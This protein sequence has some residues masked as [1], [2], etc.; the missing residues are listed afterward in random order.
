MEFSGTVFLVERF[1]E[2]VRFYRDLLGCEVMAGGEEGPVAYF[3]SGGQR[4]VLF[5]SAKRV[6]GIETYD[7]PPGAPR[8]TLAFLAADVDA[9]FARLEAAGVP[10][11][12]EPHDF[13][14]WGFR[15]SL[16]EDPSGNPV[17]IYAVL[18]SAAASGS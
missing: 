6:T 10:V 13:P 16:Y 2:C 3:V 18:S 7:G 5:D 17:E 4:F 11:R 14:E 15:S 9:E 1:A 12:L 8:A